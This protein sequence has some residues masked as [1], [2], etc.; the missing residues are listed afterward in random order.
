MYKVYCMRGAGIIIYHVD[1]TTGSLL[2]LIGTEGKYLA[3]TNPYIRQ[4]E[5]VPSDSDSYHYCVTMAKK[6]SNMSK[7]RVH[8][9]KISSTPHFVHITSGSRQGIIKGGM[10]KNDRYD[11]TQTII[12][13]MIEEIGISITTGV[14]YLCEYDDFTLF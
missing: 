1:D 7:H 3:N 14:R 10:D 8:V 13:E 11:M 12:R 9:D 4:L 2:I 6:L 5:R